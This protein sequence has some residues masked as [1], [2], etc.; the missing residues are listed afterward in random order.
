MSSIVPVEG[1]CLEAPGLAL[2]IGAH[3]TGSSSDFF[4][5]F[6]RPGARELRQILQVAL[7]CTG[8]AVHSIFSQETIRGRK[9]PN[10]RPSSTIITAEARG[11][12]VL[13]CRRNRSF[14][15]GQASSKYFSSVSAPLALSITNLS[16]RL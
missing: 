8:L 14:C 5:H 13:Y 3:R 4:V 11:Q 10:L 7:V 2:P 9:A 12:G 6:F 16:L 15:S 1:R